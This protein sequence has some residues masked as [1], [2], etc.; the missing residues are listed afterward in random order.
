MIEIN[1][2]KGKLAYL[3]LLAT[4]LAQ[5]FIS[6]L[7]FGHLEQKVDDLQKTVDMLVVR[8]LK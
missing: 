5:M 6:G 3:L 8:A 4:I 1:G 7:R 2:L